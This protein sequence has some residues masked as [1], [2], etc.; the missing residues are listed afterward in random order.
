MS[1][2][3]A[4]LAEP[5]GSVVLVYANRDEESVIFG[6][7]LRELTRHHPDRLLV[8]HHL[9]SLQGL[10]TIGHLIRLCRP[11]VPETDLAMICGPQ[12]YMDVC[13]EALT[14]LDVPRKMI[15]TER[16]RSLESDPFA[17][18]PAEPLTVPVGQEATAVVE[19]DGERRQLAWP[20]GVTLLDL[21]LEQGMEA[22]FSCRE[23][24][25]SACACRMLSGE[26][27]LLRNE[28]LDDQDLA[29]GYILA[30]QAVPAAERIEVSYDE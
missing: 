6:R 16:Y 30:C 17:A 18:Q 11:Y 3:R 24:A 14:R 8:L 10:P 22:P 15:V 29:D 19:L 23:G 4:R 20:A 2:L 7:E 25:C 27:K 26:V 13:T 21:L 5:E 12:P 28:V 9:E 1:I